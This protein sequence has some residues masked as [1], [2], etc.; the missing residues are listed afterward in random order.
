MTLQ[1]VYQALMSLKLPIAYYSFLEGQAPDVPYIIYYNPE[2]TVLKADNT[3]YIKHKRIIV[4]VYTPQKDIELEN[5]I[6]T[7]F[8]ELSFIYT[9]QETYLQS[10][11][12]Y[13]LAY[14]FFI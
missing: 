6:E 8:D 12:M 7:L 11:R 5:Q 14:D 10:E 13:M 4:E 9:K 2:D 3:N 1:D